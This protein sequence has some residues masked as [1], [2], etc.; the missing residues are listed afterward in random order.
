MAMIVPG[1]MAIRNMKRSEVDLAL[2]WAAK[3]GWNPGIRDAEPFFRADPRGFFIGEVNGEAAAMGSLVSYPG[4]MSF[5]GFLI[6]RPDLRGHGL[7]RQMLRFLMDHGADRN[8]MGDG[9]PAMVPTYLDKGFSFSHWNHRFEG[10]GEQNIF[11]DLVPVSEVP[12]DDL[13][14]YDAHVFQASR[15]EF[16]RSFLTQEGTTALACIH[17][18]E[19]QGYGAIRPCRTGHRVGPLFAEDR[20]T[21]ESIL[22]GL[23]STIPGQRYFLDVPELNAVGMA[24]ARDIG[25]TES[26]RTARIYTKY[27]PATFFNKMFGITSYELG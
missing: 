15:R 20:T 6:V 19:L 24:L 2:E 1:S 27:I 17:N 18:G 26:F 21:A 25:L 23:I 14:R 9:V 22:H 7:G 3:E 13:I 8:V 16:L 5:A 11:A 4:D 12:F 10:L